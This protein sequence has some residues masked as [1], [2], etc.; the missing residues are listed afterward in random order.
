[1][2]V[3][4][5]A[6]VV[7]GTALT[8]PVGL[9]ACSSGAATCAANTNVTVNGGTIT[10][11]PQTSALQGAGVTTSAVSPA[12]SSSNGGFHLPISGGSVNN[13]S[14]AGTI[15]TNG[16]IKFSGPAGR[17]VSLTHFA[18]NTQNGVVTTQ[19]NGHS[20]Q[21]LQ[22]TLSTASK[23]TSSNQANVSGLAS[24]L[25]RAGAVALN[26]DLAIAA[27]TPGVQLGTFT[28]GITYSC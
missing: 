22:V 10:Y 14:L 19:V 11:T 15:N 3:I 27:F 1:M 21:L 28:G 8:L 13:A 24:T 5:R 2:G 18:I 25:A 9:V 7:L 20:V 26:Q 6:G 17:S 23:S 4:H 16:G 12:T